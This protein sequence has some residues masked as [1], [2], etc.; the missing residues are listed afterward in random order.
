MFKYDKDCIGNFIYC[1]FKFY[2]NRI[3]IRVDSKLKFKLFMIRIKW[4]ILNN[5]FIVDICGIFEKFSYCIGYF[6]NMGGIVS[7]V[8]FCLD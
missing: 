5:D 8:L 2:F 3:W 4:N 6:W 7:I 1:Y